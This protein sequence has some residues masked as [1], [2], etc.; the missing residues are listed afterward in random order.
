LLDDDINVKICDYGFSFVKNE[1]RGSG[2]IV[3]PEYDAPE[4]LLNRRDFDE[5][6]D[7]YS[8]AI[9]FNQLF[10]QQQPFAGLQPRVIVASVTQNSLRPQS[11]NQTPIPCLRIIQACWLQ[12]ATRRPPFSKLCLIFSQPLEQLLSR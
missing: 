3:G 5:K 6:V 10:T 12:D 2:Y 1:V 9:I 11:S 7:V 4:M 8:F